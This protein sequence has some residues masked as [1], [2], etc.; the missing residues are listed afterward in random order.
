MGVMLE[1][2]SNFA[3]TTNHCGSELAREEVGTFNR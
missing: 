1:P 2:R 3:N